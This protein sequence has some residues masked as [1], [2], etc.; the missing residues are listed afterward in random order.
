MCYVTIFDHC[1]IKPDRERSVMCYVTIFDH[2]WIKPDR[3]RS[4]DVLCNHIYLSAGLSLR[5]RSVM[6]YVTIFDLTAGLS[7][8]ERGH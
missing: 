7:L 8:T 5:E 1:W 2:C 6:C 3:E 4:N